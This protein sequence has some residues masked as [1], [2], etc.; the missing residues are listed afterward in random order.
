MKQVTLLG[1][2]IALTLVTPAFAAAPAKHAKPPAGTLKGV[3]T[4]REA[5]LA[6]SQTG[7]GI[8]TTFKADAT[9]IYLVGTLVGPTGTKVGVRWTAVKVGK[10][11]TNKVVMANTWA[12]TKPNQPFFFKLDAKGKPKPAGSYKAEIWMNGRPR[13][14]LPFTVK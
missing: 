5:H 7:H 13:M 11:A 10:L 14:S 8:T 9:P 6:T 4:V 3:A 12:S 2:A 1:L